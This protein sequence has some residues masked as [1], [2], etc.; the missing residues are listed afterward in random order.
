MQRNDIQD[1]LQEDFEPGQLPPIGPDGAP[2]IPPQRRISAPAPRL[3]EAGP[4]VNYHRFEIQL[5]VT[6]PIAGR[7]EE[8]GKL[9]GDAPPMPFHTRV[10]HYCYPTVGIETDLGD[11]PVLSCN[12][13]KPLSGGELVEMTNR[14]EAFY[15][16]EDGQAFKTAFDTWIAEQTAERSELDNAAVEAV[17]IEEGAAP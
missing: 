13:W 9:A 2:E 16:R 4:C 12:R 14:E 11:L 5:D 1:G 15:R 7:V 17:T 8:G 10:C 3:C 6:R